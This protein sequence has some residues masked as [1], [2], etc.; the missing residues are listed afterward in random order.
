MKEKILIFGAGALSL[1]FLGPTLIEN[2]ELIF[3]DLDIK[4]NLIKLLQKENSYSIN[5][6]YDKVVPLD[7]SG[8]T[9]FN[10]SIGEE[11]EKVEKILKSIKIV[12]TAVGSEGIDK[13]LNF[14]KN[15]SVKGR[16]EKLYVFLSENDKSILR[17]WAGK[18]GEKVKLY[19]TVMGR[20]CRIDYSGKGY[21]PIGSGFKEVIVAENFYGL[22][23]SAEIYN[24]VG[25]KGKFW[26]VMS[27]EEFEARAYLKLFAHNGVHAYLSYLGALQGLKYFYE[28]GQ[29]ILSGAKILL[30]EEVIPA[31]LGKYGNFLTPVEIQKYCSQLIKRIIN[32]V[33]RDTVERGIRNSLNKITPEERLIQGA[34]FILENGLTP[35][36]FCR[37]IA[38]CIKLNVKKGMLSDSLDKTI[39]EHCHIKEEKLIALIKKGMEEIP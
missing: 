31:I 33:F 10:L 4:K 8:V 35:E 19:D 12:F 30:D 29:D 1:G 36:Y 15:N 28:V 17:K 22:P 23:V 11:R 18:L 27:D 39:S 14:I 6:C 24:Q 21:Q 9:G 5:I 37:I 26:Q 38:A 20:M 34:K 25:L 2:Y 32:P 16:K 13:T 3:C 7:I